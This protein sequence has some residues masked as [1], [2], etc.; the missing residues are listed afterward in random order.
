MVA[1]PGHPLLRISM[2]Q[3]QPA[4]TTD[5]IAVAK[6]AEMRLNRIDQNPG[7]PCIFK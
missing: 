4:S 3:S 7:E 2:S 5:A 6:Y 1:E